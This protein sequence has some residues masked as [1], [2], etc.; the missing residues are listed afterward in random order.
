MI[1]YTKLKSSTHLGVDK[2]IMFTL[3]CLG[4]AAFAII[5]RIPSQNTFYKLYASCNLFKTRAK[6]K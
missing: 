1:K 6:S 3:P 5:P 4:R 2:K